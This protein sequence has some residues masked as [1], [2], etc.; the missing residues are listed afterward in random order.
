[1][2][3]ENEVFV[4]LPQWPSCDSVEIFLKAKAKEHLSQLLVSA[5]GL[6]SDWGVFFGFLTVFSYEELFITPHFLLVQ[7]LKIN[8]K[9]EEAV[10]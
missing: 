9:Q 7:N 3:V 4:L 6:C 1:M 5:E 10:S 8:Q 2:G